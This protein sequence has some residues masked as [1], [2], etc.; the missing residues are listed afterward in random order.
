MLSFFA[1][2]P[3]GLSQDDKRA[4]LVDTLQAISDRYSTS[5]S[6]YV[7]SMLSGQASSLLAFSTQLRSGAWVFD[8][9]TDSSLYDMQSALR[10]AFSAM[11]LSP[12]W[13]MADNAFPVI[14]VMNQQC[15]PG[16]PG[17]SFV[18]MEGFNETSLG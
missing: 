16:V 15:F 7:T 3:E 10:N 14:L 6:N 1:D 2:R 12:A 18:T 11:L 4:T 17:H 9:L 13:K 8:Q 5:I